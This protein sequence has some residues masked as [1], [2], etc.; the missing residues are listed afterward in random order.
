M[1]RRPARV[2][3]GGVLSRRAAGWRGRSLSGSGHPTGFQQLGSW[4]VAFA[5]PPENVSCPV[6]SC[7]SFGLVSLRS[8]VRNISSVRQVSRVPEE[9]CL[10]PSDRN[11]VSHLFPGASLSP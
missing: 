3:A 2:L 9:G 6:P 8:L 11:A 1:L 10:L 5:V 4:F 7:L